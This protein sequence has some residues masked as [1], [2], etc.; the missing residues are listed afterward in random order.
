MRKRRSPTIVFPSIQRLPDD[1][2]V[3]PDVRSTSTPLL[4]AS[5]NFASTCTHEGRNEAIA[6]CVLWSTLAESHL[7]VPFSL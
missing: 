4:S 1:H 7:P 6:F 3:S 2:A 5:W